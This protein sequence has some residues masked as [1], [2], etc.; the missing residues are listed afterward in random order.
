MQIRCRFYV[1]ILHTNQQPYDLH[2]ILTFSLLRFLIQG[3]Y[4]QHIHPTL[5]RPECQRTKSPVEFV[6]LLG[7]DHTTHLGEVSNGKSATMR[8]RAADFF[9]GTPLHLPQFAL[10]VENS[11]LDTE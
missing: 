1:Y 5:N 3:E 9:V 10:Y 6:A 2:A 11:I 7:N 4:G 8:E